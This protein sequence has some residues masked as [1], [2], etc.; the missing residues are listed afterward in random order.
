MPNKVI[1]PKK[2]TSPTYTS[3]GSTNDKGVHVRRCDAERGSGLEENN[4]SDKHE[5]KV[6]DSVQCCPFSSL[7]V[8]LKWLDVCVCVR[9]PTYS[10]KMAHTDP[11]GKAVPIQ[12]S[13]STSPN[14][15]MMAD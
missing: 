3:N 9:L 1:I 12:V 2:D 8:S 15:S 13:F 5:F 11:S 10:G 6:E 7:G 14:C 4:A